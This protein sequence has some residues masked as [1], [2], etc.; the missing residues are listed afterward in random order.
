MDPAESL[1]DCSARE[2]FEETGLTVDV[3]CMVKVLSDL[4]DFT[5]IMYPDGNLVQYVAALFICSRVA[6][7]LKIS[8]ESLDIGYYFPKELPEMTLLSTKLRIDDALKHVREHSCL[9]EIGPH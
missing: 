7:E 3:K 6:G 2:L 4:R 1:I 8:D 5:A 9:E